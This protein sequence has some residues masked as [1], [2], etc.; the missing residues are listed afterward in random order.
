MLLALLLG[1]LF[2]GCA[3]PDGEHGIEIL[4]VSAGEF[5][6]ERSLVVRQKV[7]LSRDA[8]RALESGVA[9]TI[10]VQGR[11]DDVSA[12]R[13]FEIRYLPL[14]DHYQVLD[15]GGTPLGTWPRLRHALAELSDV[16]LPLPAGSEP[17]PGATASART[18]LLVGALPRPMR[19]PAW[20]SAG[21]RHDSGWQSPAEAT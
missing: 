11:I 2:N 20:L 12:T 14:S 13:R 19:L 8:R 10:E 17:R 4:A 7:V 15:G 9:L 5:A 21:W 16:A 3:A 18:R 6:A 1:L